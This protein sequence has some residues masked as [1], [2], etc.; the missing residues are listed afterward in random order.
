MKNNIKI[1]ALS[2]TIHPYPTYGYG[3]RNCAD[4]FRS[5]NFTQTQKKWIKTIFRLN[6]K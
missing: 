6:G 2:D 3:L 4:Q 1:T 5:L